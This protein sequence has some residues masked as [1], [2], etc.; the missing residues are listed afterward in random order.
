MPVPAIIA[1]AAGEL[2]R[3]SSLLEKV[4]AGVPAEH[5]LRRPGDQ[6]NHIAWIAGHMLWSRQMLMEMLGTK[7]EHPGL[8]VFARSAK[9]EKGT[10]YPEPDVLLKAW[11]EAAAVLEKTLENVSTEALA[12]PAPPGPP[13][14]DGKVSGFIGVMA[15]HETY[16]LGQ[17]AYLRG[18]LG[19]PGMFG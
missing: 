14:Q 16:H 15:W 9:I 13:S 8:K 1:T 6:S 7:W 2:H 10:A 11:H 17:L 19:Y 18:W 4:V 3:N 12:E 5:W